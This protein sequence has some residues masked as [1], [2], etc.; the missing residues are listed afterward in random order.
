MS[1]P[2]YPYTN[3]SDTNLDWVITTLKTLERD[4]VTY[5]GWKEEHEQ[6]YLEL[7]KII[8]DFNDGK[9]TDE[10][11]ESLKLWIVNN[12]N[13]LISYAIKNVWFGLT[14]SGYF[15]AYIPDSWNDII[16]NTIG[17]DIDVE[18]STNYGR[19]CLSY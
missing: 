12:V 6:E 15:V 17:Y 10:F 14:D 19:L 3:M 2:L 7:K 11:I 18:D 8:D 13:D 5:V 16:F 1:L 4:I 9:F